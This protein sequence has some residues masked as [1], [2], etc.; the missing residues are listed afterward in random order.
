MEPQRRTLPQIHRHL[1]R[2]IAGLLLSRV[3]IQHDIQHLHPFRVIYLYRTNQIW[4]LS[5]KSFPASLLLLGHNP[6]INCLLLQPILGIRLLL[7]QCFRQLQTRPQ[8]FVG[9]SN[10][11]KLTLE[12]RMRDCTNDVLEKWG[13]L[14]TFYISLMIAVSRILGSNQGISFVSSKILYSG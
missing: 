8:N 10:M 6:L 1:I 12:F 5:R 4:H 14:L 2:Q 3:V 9:F 11:L 13:T 7:R